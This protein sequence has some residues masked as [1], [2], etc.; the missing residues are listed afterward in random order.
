[1]VPK[2]EP[3]PGSSR[4]W[5]TK[6]QCWVAV[7]HLNSSSKLVEP[8]LQVLRRIVDHA[9]PRTVAT[10]DEERHGLSDVLVME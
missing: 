4:W 3:C 1:M 9:V 6:Q 7:K 10:I 5:D 2:M 8:E